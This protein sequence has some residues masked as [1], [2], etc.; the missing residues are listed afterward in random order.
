[1]TWA[2]LKTNIGNGRIFMKIF[3]W[4][5]SA[6]W[7]QDIKESKLEKKKFD[8]NIQILIMFY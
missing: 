6:K 2:T 1:M 4:N 8:K 7:S 5:K 3:F